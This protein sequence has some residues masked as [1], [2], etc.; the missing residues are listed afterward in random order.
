MVDPP[1]SRRTLAKPRRHPWQGAHGWTAELGERDLRFDDEAVAGRSARGRLD[2]RQVVALD[3]VAI[4]AATTPG[5]RR[6][7]R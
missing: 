5:R 2:E 3:H 1:S 4:A 7:P 6:D